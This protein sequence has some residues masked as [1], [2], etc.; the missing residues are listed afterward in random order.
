MHNISGWQP[1][2]KEH[3]KISVNLKTILATEVI[4]AFCT[5]NNRKREKFVIP[6]MYRYSICIRKLEFASTAITL[7]AVM[8]YSLGECKRR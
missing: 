3:S 4:Q 7:H 1:N 2:S 5:Y 6:R 8:I